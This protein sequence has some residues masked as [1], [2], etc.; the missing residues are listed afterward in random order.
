MNVFVGLFTSAAIVLRKELGDRYGSLIALMRMLFTMVMLA[1]VVI[2]ARGYFVDTTLGRFLNIPVVLPLLGLM[3]LFA[4]LWTARVMG[5]LERLG[6]LRGDSAPVAFSGHASDLLRTL[7]RFR[8]EW[9]L[10]DTVEPAILILI[11]FVFVLVP[12][13]RFVGLYLILSAVA[14]LWQTTTDRRLNDRSPT[15]GGFAA[16]ASRMPEDASRLSVEQQL[17]DLPEGLLALFDS[18]TQSNIRTRRDLMERALGPGTDEDEPSEDTDEK[19]WIPRGLLSAEPPKYLPYGMVALVLLI[20]LNLYGGDPAG[21]YQ[22]A[23]ARWSLAM[24]SY[25]RS[26]SKLWLLP[27]L[28][29][30]EPGVLKLALWE[31]VDPDAIDRYWIQRFETSRVEAS[32]N[33]ERLRERLA[34]MNRNAVDSIGIALDAEASFPRFDRLLIRDA[35]ARDAWAAA[36]AAV[37]TAEHFL[38]G[39][40]AAIKSQVKNPREADIVAMR[41][42]A[43]EVIVHEGRS[44]IITERV[45]QLRRMLV[46]LE[47]EEALDE[48]DR[49]RN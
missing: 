26:A 33:I 31:R 39:A 42:L 28:D 17:L 47:A 36:L 25:Q 14:V 44:T 29:E 24:D 38:R 5:R 21:V 8:N 3:L 35:A 7:R 4:G 10:L 6:P 19:H 40:D 11:G 48:A 45:Q 23:P 30:F 49:R 41:S 2:W 43:E 34:I 1:I 16:V 9:R 27:R 32:T 13:V 15:F 20:A 18:E 22:L 12:P 37:A 46:T